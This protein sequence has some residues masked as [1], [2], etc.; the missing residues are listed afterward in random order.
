MHGRTVVAVAREQQLRRLQDALATHD[1]RRP[2]ALRAVGV[3]GND[4]S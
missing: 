1:V 2:A 3:E 4:I